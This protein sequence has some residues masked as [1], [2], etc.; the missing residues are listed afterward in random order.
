LYTCSNLFTNAI[1][2][3][4]IVI[5]SFDKSKS[6]VAAFVVVFV[7][8]VAVAAVEFVRQHPKMNSNQYRTCTT[9]RSGQGGD[10]LN[11]RPQPMVIVFLSLT[12]ANSHVFKKYQLTLK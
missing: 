1:S 9:E 8:V 6:S 11:P 12:A 2:R 10:D 3:A 4:L 7:L 5:I